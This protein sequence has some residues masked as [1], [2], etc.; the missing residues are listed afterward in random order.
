MQDGSPPKPLPSTIRPVASEA[1]R[2][3]QDFGVIVRQRQADRFDDW[4]ARTV[5]RGVAPLRRFA[6]GLQADYDLMARRRQIG[7]EL[8]AIEPRAA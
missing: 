8:S 1:M 4:L 3:A 7:S 6:P 5:A 2:L